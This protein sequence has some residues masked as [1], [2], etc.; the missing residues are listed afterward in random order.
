MGHL[1]TA[2]PTYAG[3]GGTL[4]GQLRSGY[5]NDRYEIDLGQGL[6][7]FTRAVNGLKTWQA[8]RLPGISV[9]PKD[10]P[11]RTGALVVVT[12][13]AR[14]LSLAAPCRVVGVIDEPRRWGFAYGT[15][16]GHPEQGEEAFIVSLQE[17]ETVRFVVI[18][19]SRPA[20]VIVRLSGPIGRGVQKIGT[21]G[22]LRAL[23]RYVD[24]WPQTSA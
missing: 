9:F 3:V 20:D 1:E 5:H 16:P 22:Y 21:N 2:E 6:E 10:V 17:D 7:K 13:G 24:G 8:H 18:A 23:E 11:I 19:F 14:F 4:T 12:L 15:L